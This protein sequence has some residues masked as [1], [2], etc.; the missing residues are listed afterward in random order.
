MV[1][2]KPDGPCSFRSRTIGRPAHAPLN[3]DDAWP[4]RQT[5]CRAD[6]CRRTMPQAYLK[7]RQ[8]EAPHAAPS[9]KT[10]IPEGRTSHRRMTPIP[11]STDPR[12]SAGPVQSASVLHSFSDRHPLIHGPNPVAPEC[13]AHLASRPLC[14]PAGGTGPH[15]Q[16][17][18]AL[19]RSHHRPDAGHHAGRLPAGA[20]ARVSGSAAVRR[21]RRIGP[22][23]ALRW[24]GRSGPVHV[25]IGRL[26]VWL[27][28]G[29]LRHGLVHADAATRPHGRTDG[30]QRLH[31][32]HGWRARVPAPHGHHR[33]DHLRRHDL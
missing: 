3:A 11:D 16:D 17:R 24:P 27:R 14:R 6:R 23:G 10:L 31:R 5:D 25:A 2:R 21:S 20:L 1:A 32:L 9:G 18:P 8:R 30:C 13:A 4:G 22:A 29:R 19:R 26:P 28:T 7:A 15:S 12:E 33:P